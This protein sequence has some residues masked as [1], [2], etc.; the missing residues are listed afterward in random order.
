MTFC[1]RAV[2]WLSTTSW[3]SLRSAYIHLGRDMKERLHLENSVFRWNG[4]ELKIWY[5]SFLVLKYIICISVAQLVREV[6]NYLSCYDMVHLWF[7]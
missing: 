2:N 1:L 7:M 3:C 4:R 6:L 5:L